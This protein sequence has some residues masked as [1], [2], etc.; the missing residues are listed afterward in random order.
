MTHP[1]ITKQVN[2]MYQSQANPPWGR[3]MALKL[4]HNS[5]NTI[6]RMHNKMKWSNRDETKK[7][8]FHTKPAL[9]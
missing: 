6:N 5:K 1:V 7:M 9:K 8:S 3:D 4:Q 2:M